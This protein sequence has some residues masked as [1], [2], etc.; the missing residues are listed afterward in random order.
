MYKR[1]TA[2]LAATSLLVGASVPALAQSASAAPQPAQELSLGTQGE[3]AQFAG[4]N[5]FG[6]VL[7]AAFAVASVW[8]LIEI[9]D[10]DDNERPVSP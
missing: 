8:A 10:D 6:Y 4:G 1:V 7:L 9:T 5:V 2:A 3:S